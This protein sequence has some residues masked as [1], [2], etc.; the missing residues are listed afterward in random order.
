M[1]R[2]HLCQF[3][4]VDNS[5]IQ[6]RIL[7]ETFNPYKEFELWENVNKSSA[8]SFFIGRVRPFDQY[9]NDLRK[10]EIVHYKGMTE[11]YIER[12]L[13]KIS[14]KQNNL[15]ILLLHRIGFIY[16]DE[17]IILI[18]VS[19]NHRGISNKC[20]QE[21]LEFTKYKVPLWKKEWTFKGSSWVK[22]N[23]DLGFEL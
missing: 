20:L 1:M 14:K 23:T 2:W 6:F 4:L 9:G 7:E 17:P 22:K 5:K 15:S 16:P 19:A 13:M 11:K 21:I 3:L 8:N 10:L 12:N 18:A